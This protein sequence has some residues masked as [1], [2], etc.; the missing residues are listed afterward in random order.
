MSKN[1]MGNERE[2]ISVQIKVYLLNL[3]QIYTV[4]Q[5]SRSHIIWLDLLCVRQ[6]TCEK[7]QKII[8]T[9]K[10]FVDRQFAGWNAQHFPSS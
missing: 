9:S 10:Q 8:L 4:I 2:S 6:K 5:S 3:Y 7:T 1:V